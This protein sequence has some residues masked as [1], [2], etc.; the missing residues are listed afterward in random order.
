MKKC[1]A[2]LVVLALATMSSVLWLTASYRY[3]VGSEIV[4]TD[5][6]RGYVLAMNFVGDLN[7]YGRTNF[8]NL[9]YFFIEDDDISIAAVRSSDGRIVGRMLYSPTADA[10]RQVEEDEGSETAFAVAEAK[11]GDRLIHPLR[12]ITFDEIEPVIIE[13]KLDAW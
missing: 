7:G 9:S 3:A 8:A 1:V 13:L 11:L 6:A 5:F 2:L 4:T 10:L 12:F